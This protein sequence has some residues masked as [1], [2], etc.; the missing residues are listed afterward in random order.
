MTFHDRDSGDI[1]VQHQADGGG[2]RLVGLERPQAWAHDVLD[3]LPPSRTRITDAAT[4]RRSDRTQQV[5]YGDDPAEATSLVDDRE[6]ARVMQRKENLEIANRCIRSQ[7]LDGRRHDVADHRAKLL[8]G[9]SHPI[10]LTPLGE[11]DLDQNAQ[12][13]SHRCRPDRDGR[14]LGGPYVLYRAIGAGE[15]R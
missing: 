13:H 5:E 14:P 6:A 10:V 4:A 1:V 3:P 2:D 12:R 15:I 9:L 11:N 8:S 7:A